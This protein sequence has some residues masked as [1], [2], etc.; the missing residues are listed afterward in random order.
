M[1]S[2]E[3]GPQVNF[4]PLHSSE[5]QLPNEQKFMRLM[6]GGN[7]AT[8]NSAN[9]NDEKAS[10]SEEDDQQPAISVSTRSTQSS[11][12]NTLSLPKHYIS[13]IMYDHQGSSSSM[14]SFGGSYNKKAEPSKDNFFMHFGR[15]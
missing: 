5:Q 2:F 8:D 9:N 4:R 14:P 10:S 6:N 7:E 13:S 11:R 15:K 12:A 3:Q 1:Y